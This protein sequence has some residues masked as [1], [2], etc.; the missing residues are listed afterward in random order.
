MTAGTDRTP[1]TTA[2][3][4]PDPSAASS[5][6]VPS[7]PSAPAPGAPRGPRA[8]PPVLIGSAALIGAVALWAILAPAQ[9][10]VVI[11]A[12]VTWTSQNLGWYY[13]VTAG[14]VVAFVLLLALGRTGAVKLGPDHARP[15]FNLFTWTA[16]LFAAGI[17]IDLMFF[18]VSEP[19]SQYYEPPTG[20]GQNI[21]A[22][23]QAIVWTLFHYGPV[24]WAMYALMGA[25]FAYFAYRRNMPLS[26]R[27][28]LSPL[29]GRRMD[30]WAGHTVDIAA[31]LGT[32]FGIATSL[33][34]GVV[35]LNYGL[36]QLFGLPEG[37]GAQIGLIV[38]SVLMATVSTVS[39][40]EKGIRRLSELNVILAIVL[41][42]YIAATGNTRRILEGLVM[43][44]GDFLSRFPGMLLDTFAWEQPDTW[45]STWTLF[46]WAWWIA[47]APFVGLFLA[48]ISRGRSLRQFVLGVLVVPFLFIALFISVFGNSALELVIGGDDAFGQVAMATP[49]R[50]FYDLLAQYP[51]ATLLIGLA[52]L[53]GLLFYVTSA[54]S[55]ALVLANFTSVIEDPKQDGATWMRVF[56]AVLTGVL[57]LAMLLVGGITTLQ[58]ATLVIGV[59]FSIVM[60]LVMVS[61]YRALRS[62]TQQVDSFRATLVARS[63]ASE[64][65]W[66]SRLRRSM[67]YPQ[68]GAT[69]RYL[70]RTVAPALQEVA[71]EMREGGA[72]VDVERQDVEGHPVPSLVLRV[73]LPGCDDFVYQVHPV[74]QPM[75]SFAVRVAPEDDDYYRLEVFTATGSRGYD[76]YGYSSEHLITDVLDLYESHLE[77]LRV[78][79][80]GADGALASAVTTDWHED[81]PA[82]EED[83]EGPSADGDPARGDQADEDRT[84]DEPAPVR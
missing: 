1:T 29:F 14:I 60:Y 43:N 51:G 18:S 27:T 16:M 5:A 84:D 37:V 50:A 39:G 44:V 64:R 70:E 65:S 75:P 36:H 81:F 72:E 63:G 40:V 13:I 48:R 74:A 4:T 25:A 2:P 83:P 67:S 31:V 10:G 15:Q 54:D 58:G 17:G 24:G 47:W 23:R 20:G 32:V 78:S 22:A 46:F 21:E 41:L 62:E 77:Y 30:G 53:T 52:T 26:I 71:S 66:R 69:L 12:I 11:G 19:I 49:E 35:Q 79:Q 7:G 68:R 82:V 80:G 28:L 6:A 33:G 8:N 55:G 76:V 73:R 38:L 3:P 45:S 59:P 9:A 34:I 56:W 57:T 42:V 61:L